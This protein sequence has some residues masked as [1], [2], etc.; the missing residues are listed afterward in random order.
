M[1]TM[2][3]PAKHLL[4]HYQI[5]VVPVMF[6]NEPWSQEKLD[7]AMKRGPHKSANEHVE[8]LCEDF[9][10]MIDKSQWIILPYDKVKELKGLR[11]S[12]PGVIPQR[13]QCP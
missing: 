8:F 2:Q 6:H 7:A 10:Y 12:P 3:H 4:Q 9:L 1:R 11:L 5:N 13:N